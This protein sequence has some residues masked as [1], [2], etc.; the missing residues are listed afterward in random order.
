MN[1]SMYEY[2]LSVYNLALVK[3]IGYFDLT[4]SHSQNLM[5]SC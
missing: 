4:Q 5:K 1:V 2:I 3:S